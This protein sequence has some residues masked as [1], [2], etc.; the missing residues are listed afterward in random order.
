M[1]SAGD[2][3]AAGG[4]GESANRVPQLPQK[5]IPGGLLKPQWVQ[6]I[7]MLKYYYLCGFRDLTLL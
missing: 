1:S 3:F 6:R 5:R 2:D 4:A 7:A